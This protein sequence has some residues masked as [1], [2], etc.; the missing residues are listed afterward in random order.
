MMRAVS[1][2]LENPLLHVLQK[3]KNFN[4]LKQV[5]AQMITT[6]LILH[7][8]SI[9]RILL[10]SSS[11][12]PLSYT[13]AIFSRAPNPSIF[14]HNTLI[15]CLTQNNQL[16]VALSLYDQILTDPNLKPNNYT[17]PSLFKAFAAH[18]LF[19]HG[20]ALYTH[21]LKFSYPLNDNFVQASLLNFYS[22]FGR[23]DIARYFFDQITDPD[24][25]SWNSILTAYAR[26]SSVSISFDHGLLDKNVSSS[27]E[28]LNLFCQMQKSSVEPN[29]VTLVS[30]ITACAQLGALSQGIWA[31]A[32]LIKKGLS[33]NHYV[34]TSLITLYANSGCLD[35]A[36]QLFRR[37][38]YTDIFCFNAMIRALAIHGCGSEALELFER[39]KQEGPVPDDVTMVA[40][41]CS[42]SHMG[43]VTEGR[44]YFESM[45]RIYGLEPKIEHF[46]CLVDLLGRAG[47]VKEAKETILSMPMKP[48]AVLWR[49]LLGAARI[50]GDLDTGEVAL[51]NL[52]ELEPETSGNYVLLSNTYSCMEKWDDAKRVRQLMKERGVDKNPGSS[53]VEVDGEMHEF[54]I[55]DKSHPHT[56]D[57]YLKL[58]EMN[59]KLQEYGYR[60]K[61]REVLFD[62]EEEEKEDALSY[63]SERLA[64][65]F[66]LIVTDSCMTI[67]IIKNLRVCVD[68][69]SIT[70]LLS[71]IYGR[72][73][74]V[75]DRIRF[76]HF[77][78]G[79]CSCMDY[80]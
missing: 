28:V 72:E 69:H 77:Q 80:W 7:T 4:T 47:L 15:S 42:C 54:I 78:K 67:R 12:S 24:L 14:L 66:A 70:K 34:G 48:N 29:E 39:M 44:E 9:S 59:A 13:L 35:F 38:L 21:V 56:R 55:G 51:K 73:I 64:I 23:M 37:L 10:I 26:N 11:L 53:L 30:L 8:Y 3:C 60:A 33:L 6:G 79:K 36:R 19:K 27:M 17:Y 32:F 68:C 71:L 2:K 1:P 16:K 5:H 25:A 49:S 20:Q 31:H 46:C 57:I 75:R 76:H 65:A 61:T 74:I 22:R 45:A 50:H 18:K 43:L 41:I 58:E 62:I 40:V 63:H 52:V